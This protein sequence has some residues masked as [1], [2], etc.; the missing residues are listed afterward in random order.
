MQSIKELILLLQQHQIRPLQQTAN[1]ANWEPKL[2]SLFEGV[3]NGALSSDATAAAHLFPGGTGGLPEFEALKSAF[4]ERLTALLLDFNNRLEQNS[5]PQWVYAEC[6]KQWLSVRLFTGENAHGLALVL[7]ERLLRI[8]EKF[9][10]TRLCMDIAL[11]LRIQYCL[12]QRD[13]A[14]CREAERRYRYFRQVYD[15][16]YQAEKAYT[17]LVALMTDGRSARPEAQLQAR[18]FLAATLPAMRRFKTANLH[19]YGSLVGIMTHMSANDYQKALQFCDKAIP[20][21]SHRPYTSSE[22]LQV[23]YYQKLLC[24]IHLK[25]YQAG[26][27]AALDCLKVS[28]VGD[29]NWFK[30]RELYLLLLLHTRHYAEAAGLLKEILAQPDFAYLAGYTSEPWHLYEWYVRLASGGRAVDPAGEQE[31]RLQAFLQTPGVFS[32]GK[33]GLDSARLAVWILLCVRHGA[34]GAV[35]AQADAIEAYCMQFLKGKNTRRSALFLRTAVQILKN[36]RPRKHALQ[37]RASFLKKLQAIPM[38]LANQTLELEVLPY[39]DLFEMLLK[40]LPDTP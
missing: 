12:R 15:A 29:F 5:D 23:F 25:Q 39:D 19:L 17:A 2:I 20:F 10:F 38:Q 4:R 33:T 18:A 3:S 27:N 1:G 6:H 30:F 36:G 34:T 22:P 32:T 7:A 28:E 24:C 9:D 11:Y 16:E 14:Q 37:Q 31:T 8:A 26:K 13:D 35:T 21:F 40:A